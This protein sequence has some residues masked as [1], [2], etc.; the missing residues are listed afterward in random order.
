MYYF[1]LP[2]TLKTHRD[3][4]SL[5]QAGLAAAASVE[6]RTIIKIEKNNGP[7]R[8]RDFVARSLAIALEV[9][10]ED[11]QKPI[12][13]EVFLLDIDVFSHLRR[14][15]SQR[16]H[17]HA[18]KIFE[19]VEYHLAE[20][21]DIAQI[22][23]GPGWETEA[24]KGPRPTLP[25]VPAGPLSVSHGTIDQGALH[26]FLATW[27]RLFVEKA[28]DPDRVYRDVQFAELHAVTRKLPVVEKGRI[29]LFWVKA[30]LRRISGIRSGE[31]ILRRFVNMD[32]ELW[33]VVAENSEYLPEF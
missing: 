12:P 11:L 32:A 27:H 6:R 19:Y 7:K 16:D 25:S 4:L 30:Y 13:E 15:L 17:Y 31:F 9:Q 29:N 18:M 20:A 1:I 23:L 24:L 33:H 21:L 26:E 10:V 14:V 5:S 22:Q 2:E 3:R 28:V 8:T